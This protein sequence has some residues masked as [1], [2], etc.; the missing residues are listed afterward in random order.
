MGQERYV[1][2]SE[3]ARRLIEKG[4]AA[5]QRLQAF[6]MENDDVVDS[7]VLRGQQLWLPHH[8]TDGREF[9]VTLMVDL[10]YP[11]ENTANAHAQI[12]AFLQHLEQELTDNDGRL[13]VGLEPST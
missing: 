5:W 2:P 12:A 9:R 6:A 1:S 11:S 13:S 3:R 8:E 4:V 10:H 7:L